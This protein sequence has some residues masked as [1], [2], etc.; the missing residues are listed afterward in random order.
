MENRQD[1]DNG[2]RAYITTVDEVEK[3]TGYDFLNSLPVCVQDSIEA[4]TYR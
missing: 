4:V 1:L 3:R 2:W